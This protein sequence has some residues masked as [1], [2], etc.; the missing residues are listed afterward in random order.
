[1]SSSAQSLVY[2]D[3]WKIALIKSPKASPS[4]PLVTVA[5]THSCDDYRVPLSALERKLHG[6]RTLPVFRAHQQNKFPVE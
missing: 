4:K 1:M 3:P 5:I 6:G 2:R